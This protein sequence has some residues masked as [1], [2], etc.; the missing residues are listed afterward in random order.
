MTV[1]CVQYIQTQIVL[2]LKL[3]VFF[4]IVC[5]LDNPSTVTKSAYTIMRCLYLSHRD[6]AGF[7]QAA[8]ETPI[9]HTKSP[10]IPWMIAY[11]CSN[12]SRRAWNLVQ[13]IKKLRYQP[14]DDAE[15]FFKHTVKVK[16]NGRVA[17]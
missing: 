10:K 17:V 6:A 13:S 15:T 16:Q 5:A 11:A 1:S 2:T 7:F 4:C 12:N 3:T 8:V 14:V 9:T